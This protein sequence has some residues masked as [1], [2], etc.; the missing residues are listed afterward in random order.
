[1][2]TKLTKPVSREVAGPDGAPLIATLTAE[3]MTVRQKGRR[4][5]ATVPYALEYL[6]PGA[7]EV[8]APKSGVLVVRLT[9]DGLAI[10][11]KGEKKEFLL[12]YGNAFVRAAQLEAEYQ[13]R[14]AKGARK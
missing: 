9:A 12:P 11:K 8:T 5:A 2:A 10:R 1:M 4:R 7:R 6:L 3:G 13:R 14:Q